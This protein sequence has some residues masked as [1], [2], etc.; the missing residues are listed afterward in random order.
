MVGVLINVAAV[1][2]GG[3]LGLALGKRVPQHLRDTVMQGLG[4]CVLVIGAQGALATQ[5][6]MIL[7]VSAVLG[8]L[9]GEAVDIEKT[10][11]RP[12]R[13]DGARLDARQGRR[14][15][16]AGVYDGEPSCSVWGRCP[17]SARWKPA[18]RAT[19]TR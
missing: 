3:L 5:N 14:A 16:H 18:L 13:A 1:L 11:G 6:V 7:I 2:A 19:T 17:L 8:G 12:W 10:V 4:L 15:F 9:V